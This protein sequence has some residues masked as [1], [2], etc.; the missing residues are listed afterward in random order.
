M[1]RVITSDAVWPA[2]LSDAQVEEIH[3]RLNLR[4]AAKNK[5]RKVEGANANTYDARKVD[6]HARKVEGND[7]QVDEDA[8]LVK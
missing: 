8:Q 6:E 1:P 5:A 7:K 4:D 3:R 2:N